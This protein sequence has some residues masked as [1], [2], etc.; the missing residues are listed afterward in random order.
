MISNISGIGGRRV[1]DLSDDSAIPSLMRR[2]NS[3]PDIPQGRSA[4]PHYVG[5]SAKAERKMQ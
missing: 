1:P 5:G 2:Y 3:L 4:L